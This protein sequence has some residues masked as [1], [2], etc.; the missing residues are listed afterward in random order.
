MIFTVYKPKR[1]RN[2]KRF[3]S[4]LYRGKYRLDN[5]LLVT[6]I[7]LKTPDK[8][9]AEERLKKIIQ[10]KQREAEGIIAPKALRDAAQKSLV[11]HLA[12]FITDLNAKRRDGMY[13]YNI[14]KRSRRVIRECEWKLPADVTADSF[15]AWRARQNKAAKTI[16]DYQDT[17][18]DL[19]NWMQRLGRIIA[20]PLRSVEKV[21]VKGHEVRQRRALTDYEFVVVCPGGTESVISDGRFYRIKKS[22]I[23]GFDMGRYLSIEW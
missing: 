20:N 13:I 9:V 1:I 10:E 12:D 3:I 16:N 19:F 4:R 22:R 11:D 17:M 5:D 2:G 8:Q 23:G 14:E 6:D 15:I 7:P 18:N 21:Q